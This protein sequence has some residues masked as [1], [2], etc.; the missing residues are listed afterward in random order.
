[1]QLTEDSEAGILIEPAAASARVCKDEGS[2]SDRQP[3]GRCLRLS[4]GRSYS[5]GSVL[6]ILP[7]RRPW[8][9]IC[10]VGSFID[11]IQRNE[12]IG[13]E[14]MKRPAPTMLLFVLLVGLVGQEMLVALD[15]QDIA[16]ARLLR[17]LHLLVLGLNMLAVLRREPRGPWRRALA[18]SPVVLDV[19][20]LQAATV[21][22]GAPSP[23][24]LGLVFLFTAAIAAK[25]MRGR[26]CEPPA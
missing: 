25:L 13:M 12:T 8:H 14:P 11:L 6:N 3:A 15:L 4:V 9:A 16:V 26:H 18:V 2:P 22:D 1:M 7:W 21:G 5:P 20:A 10:F 23:M 24:A 19:L 17:G